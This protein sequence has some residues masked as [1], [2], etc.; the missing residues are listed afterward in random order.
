MG[1]GPARALHGADPP[2]GGAAGADERDRAVVAAGARVS[3]VPRARLQRSRRRPP[4]R[5]AR[6]PLG[7]WAQREEQVVA[8]AGDVAQ[9]E[10]ALHVECRPRERSRA[11]GLRP[12]EEAQLVPEAA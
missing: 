7:A 10:L 8:D 5:R 4:G 6:T 1:G 9:S 2:L 12:P 11:E 3:L